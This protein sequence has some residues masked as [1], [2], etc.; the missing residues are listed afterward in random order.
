MRYL[1]KVYPFYVKM[2]L[3]KFKLILYTAVLCV[4]IVRQL[5]LLTGMSKYKCK[6]HCTNRGRFHNIAEG[7]CPHKTFQSSK[8]MVVI[9]TEYFKYDLGPTELVHP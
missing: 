3:N 9:L 1:R 5:S 8:E 6:S 7:H 2:C 4:P